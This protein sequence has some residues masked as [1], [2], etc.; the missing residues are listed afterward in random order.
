M[1][2]KTLDNFDYSQDYYLGKSSTNPLR[3]QFG[4]TQR[5]M[6]DYFSF[7]TGGAGWCLSKSALRKVLKQLANKTFADI[8]KECGAPDDVTVGFLLWRSEIALTEIDQFHSHLEN[9]SEISDFENQV[10]NFIQ[11]TTKIDQWP[12]VL[13]S[14]GLEVSI[15]LGTLG[16]STFRQIIDILMGTF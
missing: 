15:A 1:L 8:S 6:S 10:R 3:V 12:F 9:L 13:E 14:A 4:D 7:A 2:I 11:K 5:K 16:K